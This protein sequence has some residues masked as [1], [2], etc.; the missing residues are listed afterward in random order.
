MMA[1]RRSAEHRLGQLLNS[2]KRAEAVLGA[3][4][5]RF[6]APMHAR[7]ERRLPMNRRIQHRV[8]ENTETANSPN[9][10]VLQNSVLKYRS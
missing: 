2:S 7:R 8:L 6:M 3:P 10:C 5:A 9:L 1:R 4:T